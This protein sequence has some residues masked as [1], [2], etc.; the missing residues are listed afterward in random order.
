MKILIISPSLDSSKNISGISSVV[1]TII[2][3]G[4]NEYLHYTFGSADKD[5]Q[6]KNTKWAWGLLK[7]FSNY[8]RFLKKH[9]P[10]L[11][12]MN[13]PCDAKGILRE[14]II[15]S[16]NNKQKKKSLVHLHGGEYLMRKPKNRV[17]LYLFKK[18]L[19]DGKKVI[20][21]SSIEKDSLSKLYGYPN[22]EILHNSI[23]TNTPYKIVD[24][25]DGEKLQILFLGRIDK[26]KGIY[27]MAKAFEKLYPEHSFRFVLCGTG[28]LEDYSIETFGKIMGDDFSFEGV[29][30]GNNKLRVISESDIY[31]LP[32]FYEGLPIS[33]LETMS[34]G[35]IPVATPVGSISGIITD[36]ENGVLIEKCNPEDIYL[37]LKALF[38][39][40][41]RIKKL[42]V[43]A[44]GTMIENFDVKPMIVKLEQ[45]Y[46]ECTLLK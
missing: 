26:H 40:P 23:D 20:V 11:A 29:V 43:N 7:S 33:L 44:R 42:S 5:K 34:A 13:V 46:T 8:R 3:H 19:T 45:I 12:H 10:D 28:P 6:R 17:L 36:G 30:S 38:N 4:H 31:L 22:A 41:E 21:L 14:Y 24:K 35:I 18:I 39:D 2:A 27:D 1:G 32:S 16:I 9:N 25:K 15:L 37:K